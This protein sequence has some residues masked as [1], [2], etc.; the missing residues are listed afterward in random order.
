M[1]RKPLNLQKYDLRSSWILVKVNIG[2]MKFYLDLHN[3]DLFYF[4][5]VLE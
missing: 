4:E 1:G 5:N 3:E 2:T